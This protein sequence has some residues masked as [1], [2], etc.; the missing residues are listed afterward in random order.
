MW[1]QRDCC[2]FGHH[3]DKDGSVREV[4]RQHL[5]EAVL[6]QDALQTLALFLLEQPHFLELEASEL[7]RCFRKCGVPWVVQA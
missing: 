5:L 3:R 1:K 2:N 4:A 7:E 6:L